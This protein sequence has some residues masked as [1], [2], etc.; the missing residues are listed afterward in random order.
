MDSRAPEPVGTP[1]PRLCRHSERDPRVVL[2]T[3]SVPDDTYC[4]DLQYTLFEENVKLLES[5]LDGICSTTSSIVLPLTYPFWIRPEKSFVRK[6]SISY[7]IQSDDLMKLS[8]KCVRDL[9]ALEVVEH[10]RFLSGPGQRAPLQDQLQILPP[11]IPK[12]GIRHQVPTGDCSQVVW[13]LKREYMSKAPVLTA[14]GLSVGPK[15]NVNWKERNKPTV[16]L[17]PWTHFTFSAP[18]PSHQTI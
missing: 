7:Q 4:I 18:R 11:F 16:E 14:V 13:D 17:P 12:I 5:A 3:I 9:G 2:Y 15:T 1:Q 10:S 8:Q 6:A